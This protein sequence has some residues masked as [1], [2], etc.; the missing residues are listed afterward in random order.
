MTT[1]CQT[2]RRGRRAFT[3]I[4]VL[5]T[6]TIIAIISA[7]GLISLRTSSNSMALSSAETLSASLLQNARSLAIMNNKTVRILVNHDSSDPGR[8]LRSI[9][10]AMAQDN[11]GTVEWVAAGKAE[12]L[13]ANIFFNPSLSK[14]NGN[15][16]PVP[17]MR[18]A[19]PRG[20]AQAEGNGPEW[21]Y[22]EIGPNGM[23]DKSNGALFVLGSGRLDDS[24]NL[25]PLPQNE[26][27]GFVLRQLGTLTS[28]DSADQLPSL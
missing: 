27:R 24:G 20:E 7:I 3:L 6:L 25:V 22:F 15:G 23:A 18:L 12:T 13:P 4:E 1:Y 14:G 2:T 10:I 28:F 8:C 16:L 19:F 21:Y 9:G 11:A 26:V 17:T 5:A